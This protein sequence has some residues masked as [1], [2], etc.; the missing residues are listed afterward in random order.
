VDWLSENECPDLI[1]MDIQL[2]DGVSF[3]IFNLADVKCPVIF[4]TAYDEYAVQAF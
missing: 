1:I 2:A 3:E 4:T